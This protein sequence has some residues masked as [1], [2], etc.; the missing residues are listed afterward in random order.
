[1]TLTNRTWSISE[2]RYAHTN[3]GRCRDE[4]RD[5]HS[6]IHIIAS[7]PFDVGEAELDLTHGDHSGWMH[8]ECLRSIFRE[9]N[10]VTQVDIET[11]HH[12][13]TAFQHVARKFRIVKGFRVTNPHCDGR[14]SRAVT[15]N[16]EFS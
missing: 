9:E 12:A 2:S 13:Q 5:H 1:M 10:A 7:I 11:V 4:I 14:T 15:H 8:H 6:P 16:I 3:N